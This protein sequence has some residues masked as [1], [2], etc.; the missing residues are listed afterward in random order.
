MNKYVYTDH[1]INKIILIVRAKD[2]LEADK[3][4][5]KALN[6]NVSKH[7]YIGCEIIFKGGDLDA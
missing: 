5:E 1:K 2:I 4:F 3:L 7:N 6:Y